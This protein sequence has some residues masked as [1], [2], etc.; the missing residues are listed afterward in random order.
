[1]VKLSVKAWR[2][3]L[4]AIL[5]MYLANAQGA[6]IALALHV[7]HVSVSCFLRWLEV[8]L[9]SNSFRERLRSPNCFS[10]QQRPGYLAE[11][12]QGRSKFE[13]GAEE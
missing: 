9:S 1:M 11:V 3:L 13:R 7:R 2:Y 5:V 6:R 10:E 12:C 4:T 8:P